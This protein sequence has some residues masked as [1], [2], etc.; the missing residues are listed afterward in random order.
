VPQRGRGENLLTWRADKTL[1]HK[2]T[3]VSFWKS[4]DYLRILDQI[5]SG[6]LLM[7]VLK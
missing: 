7:Q 1:N 2:T 6:Y 5:D 4:G 3:A